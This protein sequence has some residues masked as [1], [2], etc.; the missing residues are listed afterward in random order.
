MSRFISF[1]G[2]LTLLSL[3]LSAAQAQQPK[4]EADIRQLITLSRSKDLK[5]SDTARD[6]LSKLDR[7]SLPALTSILKKGNPCE[8]VAAAQWFVQYEP[9]NKDLVPAMT[10]VATRGSLRTLFHLDEEMICRRAAAYVLGLSTDG[11]AVL[12]R[13]L[14][15]GDAWE[16]QSAVFA[17][18]DLTETSSYPDGSTPAFKELIPELAK[19]T[20]SKDRTLSCMAEEVLGQ[21]ERGSNAELAA[22]AKKYV[23]P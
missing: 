19:A 3:S 12:T 21:I 22:L 14:R 23:S 20:R 6:A 15:Q 10:D 2:T 8:R 7:N 5:T 16:R 9:N 4:T 11:I 18:D 13:L 17:L 1:V